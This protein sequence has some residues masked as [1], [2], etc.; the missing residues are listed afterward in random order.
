M[1]SGDRALSITEVLDVIEGAGQRDKVSLGEIFDS[2]GRRSYGPMLLVPALVAVFPV[3]GALPGVSIT[4]SVIDLVF[5][6]QLLLNQ[7]GPKLPK[8]LRSIEVPRRALNF[9]LR[10]ARPVAKRINPFIKSERLAWLTEK[11]FKF[12]N[13]ALAVFVALAMC[14][15]SLLPGTILPPALAMIILA[16]GL[17]SRDGVLVLLAAALAL[18]SAVLIGAIFSHLV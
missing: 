10:W 3:V 1:A 8:L 5:A 15:G 9:G 18:G 4:T 7:D 2:F 11:P 12:A 17:T 13:G 14:A 16:L 6:I